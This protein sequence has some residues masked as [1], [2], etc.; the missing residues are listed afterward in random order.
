MCDF[1]VIEPVSAREAEEV[2]FLD[3]MPLAEVEA[4]EA[5]LDLGVERVDEGIVQRYRGLRGAA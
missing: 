3:S 5:V 1:D 2:E 4:Y